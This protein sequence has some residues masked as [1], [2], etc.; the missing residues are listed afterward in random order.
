LL[1]IL[2]AIIGAGAGVILDD[3]I[4]PWC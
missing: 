2:G 1:R 4:A 3:F